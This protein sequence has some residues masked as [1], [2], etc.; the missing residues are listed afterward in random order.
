MTMITASCNSSRDSG[1][2]GLTLQTQLFFPTE[3]KSRCPSF[4]FSS[5]PSFLYI[6]RRRPF[7]NSKLSFATPK[8]HPFAN[9][10][11]SFCHTQMPSLC[12]LKTEF[13][14]SL[15]FDFL[16]CCEKKCHD[17]R[18][19]ILPSSKLCLSGVGIDFEFAPRR[20]QSERF[21]WLHLP[22]VSLAS[23]VWLSCDFDFELACC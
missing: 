6:E 1:F 2:G 9:S 14:P 4:A 10:K 20:R 22:P 8:Y 11:L 12:K 16:V 13:L 3:C 5:W 7:A 17:A 18:S 15:E 19:S 23:R 21:C